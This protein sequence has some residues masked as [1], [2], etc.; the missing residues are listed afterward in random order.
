VSPNLAA[1]MAIRAGYLV[2]GTAAA[3]LAKEGLAEFH[4]RHPGKVR[5]TKAGVAKLERETAR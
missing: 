2:S 3:Q 4:P 5:L 1:M